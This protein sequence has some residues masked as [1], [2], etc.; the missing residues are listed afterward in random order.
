RLLCL[1]CGNVEQEKQVKNLEERPCC[2]RCGSGLL[3][4]YNR[5]RQSIVSSVLKRLSGQTLTMEEQRWLTE[6]RRNADIVLSYGKKGIVALSIR[7]VGPQTASRILA[8]MHLHDEEFY[9]DLLDAKIRYM[10][11]RQYWRDS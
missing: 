6:A 1:N 10:E 8:K 5:L 2:S 3:A 4:A 7:G 9:R 11:T